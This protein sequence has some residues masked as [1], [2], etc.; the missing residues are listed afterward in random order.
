MQIGVFATRK[1]IYIQSIR[2]RIA[3]VVSVDVHIEFASLDCGPLLRSKLASRISRSHLSSAW[4]PCDLSRDLPVDWM[5]AINGGW[6]GDDAKTYSI[7]SQ[8]SILRPLL[9][10]AVDSSTPIC[11]RQGSKLWVNVRLSAWGMQ[12]LLLVGIHSLMINLCGEIVCVYKTIAKSEVKKWSDV[13]QNAWSKIAF[14]IWMLL[15]ER[16]TW[17]E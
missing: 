9:A 12:V 6:E 16:L 13:G 15:E 17:M 5:R 10:E 4:S 14:H 2:L 3:I 7:A 8:K 1:F 11:Q